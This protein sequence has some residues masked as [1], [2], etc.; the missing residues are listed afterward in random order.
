M[1]LFAMAELEKAEGHPAHETFSEGGFEL[2]IDRVSRTGKL[3]DQT[4]DP[5]RITD[6]WTDEAFLTE[7]IRILLRCITYR[8]ANEPMWMPR[9]AS[10]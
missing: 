8:M 5:E 10:A 2:Q 7:K 6:L 9:I 4:K 3:F 1:Y